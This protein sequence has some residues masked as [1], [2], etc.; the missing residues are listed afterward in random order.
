MNE[1][2]EKKELEIES[3]MP[4]PADVDPADGSPIPDHTDHRPR[5]AA[6]KKRSPL[7]PILLIGGVLVVAICAFFLIR[8]LTTSEPSAQGAFVEEKT[9]YI[10]KGEIIQINDPELGLIEIEAIEGVAKNNYD[11][12]NFAYDENGL[13]TYYIDGEQASCTG[14]DLSEYQSGVDFE[15][16]AAS[17]VD[18][19]MLR[20]GGRYYGDEGALYADALFSDY[21]D[22]AKDAGLDVGAYFF[23]QAASV[24]DGEEEA[25][26]ALT[27][28]SGRELDYPVAFDWEI[29]ADDEARTDTVTGELLTDIAERFCD[30][31]D[32]AGYTSVIYA[33][34]SLM[35]YQY[36]LSR[37][38]DYD[39]WVA[40]YGNFPTMY[41]GF[42][43]WQYTTEGT[44]DGIDGTVD[45]NMCFKNY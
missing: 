42:S 4:A 9:E 17:G 45:L 14:V 43:M 23:S 1:L 20:L 29:I 26:Y 41:Y 18:Y 19:V 22:A 7:L 30:V 13:I 35:Y 5:H 33:N 39:F 27:L 16:L 38:K 31:I 15:A 6:E 37:M 12:N 3:D 25:A 21:Y 32:Q 40:D 8:A 2:N 10:G 44:V 11:K 36:D 28:L 24:A 34:T